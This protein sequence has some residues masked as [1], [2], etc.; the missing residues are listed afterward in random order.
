MPPRTSQDQR[1]HHTASKVW[2]FL[3][4]KPVNKLATLLGTICMLMAGAVS[5]ASEC[6]TVMSAID[7]S[8]NRDNVVCKRVARNSTNGNISVWRCCPSE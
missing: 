4:L 7:P 6:T 8:Q 1:K 5:Q 3:E 2:G